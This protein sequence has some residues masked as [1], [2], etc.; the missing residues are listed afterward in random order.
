[1]PRRVIRVSYG[2]AKRVI[3]P[4][5]LDAREKGTYPYHKPLVQDP[6]NLPKGLALGSREHALILEKFDL[7]M[8]GGIN[9]ESAIIKIGELY[10]DYP[11]VFMPENFLNLE[12]WE[13]QAV[14]DWLGWILPRYGLGVN[15]NE[16]KAHWVW[17][18]LKLAKF[19]DS[20]PRKLFAV[21]GKNAEASWQ[22]YAKAKANYDAL[23][24]IIIRKKSLTHEELMATPFGFYGYAH[25][26]VNVGV[27]SYP[28][29]NDSTVRVPGPCGF[30]YP[31]CSHFN[32]CFGNEENG[33]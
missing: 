2:R 6:H 24:R 16:V 19:W 4:A 7:Y 32:G 5:L 22:S 13:L 31:S 1:M 18:S 17:N 29:R 25:K 8:K 10:E 21:A 26:M 33:G 23:C 28:C 27:F 12:T 15:V 11:E 20:D 14:I 30:P 3:F 9:S